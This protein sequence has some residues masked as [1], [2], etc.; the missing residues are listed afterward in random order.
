MTIRNLEYAVSPRS[1][2]VIGASGR[3]G[4]VGRVVF[5]NIVSGGFEGEIWP[6]NP[7]HSQVAGHRC[8]AKVA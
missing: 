3:A 7:K 8:Y 2:A 4:S 5:D 1:I 6:L